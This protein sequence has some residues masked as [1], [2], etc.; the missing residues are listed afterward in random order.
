M[1]AA[2]AAPTRIFVEG[3]LIGSTA[4]LQGWMLWTEATPSGR[5]PRR[6]T[7]GG[8]SPRAWHGLCT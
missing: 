6:L 5:D 3:F 8:E 1:L 7:N 2:A 4:F